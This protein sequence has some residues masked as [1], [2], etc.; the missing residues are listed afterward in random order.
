M[1]LGYAAGGSL[2]VHPMAS[3]SRNS[4]ENTVFKHMGNSNRFSEEQNHGGYK[5]ESP[6][7]YSRRGSAG[8]ETSEIKRTFD[9]YNPN[10]V[11]NLT[12]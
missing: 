3:S 12:S 11:S 6:R 5:S 7:F 1:S 10:I 8:K 2:G 9:H 4:P